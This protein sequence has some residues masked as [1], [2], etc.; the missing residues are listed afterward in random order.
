MKM[1]L[2]DGESTREISVSDLSVMNVRQAAAIVDAVARLIPHEGV[3]YEVKEDG[4][5][6]SFR[7]MTDKGEAWCRFIRDYERSHPTN[8]KADSFARKNLMAYVFD[9]IPVEGIDYEPVITFEGASS[10]KISFKI[11][12]KN[13]KGMFW[14]RYVAGMMSK[15]PPRAD[16]K[17][18]MLPD[19]PGPVVEDPDEFK[20]V[21]DEKIVH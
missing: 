4:A 11:E 15:Y 13:E 21:S 18:E 14:A 8:I 1:F 6:F 5:D 16:Y 19:D 12:P 10:E 20:E 17:A 2:R 7:W 3:D 9:L